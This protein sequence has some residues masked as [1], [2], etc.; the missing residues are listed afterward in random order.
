MKNKFI[1][2]KLNI[3]VEA[4]KPQSG[5]IDS[6][7][8]EI[9]QKQFAHYAYQKPKKHGI[10]AGVGAA[11]AASILLTFFTVYFISLLIRP[12]ARYELA[13]LNYE[14]A[15]ISEIES[16]SSILTLNISE[17]YTNGRIY[18]A[19]NSTTPTVISI[20]Y[21]TV[22][23]GGLDEIVVIADL[24]KGLTDYNNFKKYK[25]TQIN[26]ITVFERQLYVNGE[27]YTE[28]YFR[29]EDIDYYVIVAS[30]AQGSANHYI[31]LLIN[32]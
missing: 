24:N 21:K 13:Q 7:V 9:R 16:A 8:L 11:V 22:G 29:Y 6:A 19:E 20:L 2:K 23:S 12:E 27:Y 26:G 14:T 17:S 30:P 31:T 5:I 18:Y 25:E 28:S 32:S 4:V 1:E 3:Y 10:Y 15:T